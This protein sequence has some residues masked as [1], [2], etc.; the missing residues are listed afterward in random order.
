TLPE[1][2]PK[3]RSFGSI[4]L[5]LLSFELD[6]WGRVRKQTQAARADL[7]A[8]EEDRKAVMTTIVSG[9]AATYFNLR[10]FDYELEIAR[11]TL[12]SRQESLRIIKL[13]E[14]SGVSN[15]LE[16]RQAEELVYNATET[17]PA[18]ERSIE[19][20]ENFLSV[21]IGKNPGPIARGL[22]LTEQQMPPVVPPG[23]PSDLIARRPDIRSAEESLIASGARI[24]VARK[25]YLPKISLTGFLGFESASL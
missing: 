3:A 2:L 10:E 9:V 4:L 13:R 11:R 12:T 14:A 17:I 18:L 15:M 16:V 6:I 5:N 24:E 21:L 7:L 20:Q 22:E 23:I 8:T 1:P 25:A 19:Q